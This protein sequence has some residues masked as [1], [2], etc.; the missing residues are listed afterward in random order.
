MPF[1]IQWVWPIPLFMAA[2]FAPESEC[3]RSASI[4]SHDPDIFTDPWWLVRRGHHNEAART[5]C[6]LGRADFMT[7]EKARG[8]VA[9]MGHTLEVEK[10]STEGGGFKE[11]F[12]GT[13]LRRT[14]IVSSYD[15]KRLSLID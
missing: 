5:I 4:C 11:L 1:V 2:Y 12:R 6:R 13:N 8:R 10:R 3:R 14:E 9:M 15:C 7:S